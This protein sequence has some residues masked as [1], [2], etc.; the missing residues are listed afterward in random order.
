MFKCFDLIVNDLFYNWSSNVGPL[1]QTLATPPSLLMSAVNCIFSWPES[2][3][4]FT[5]KLCR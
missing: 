2:Q 3:I 1:N 4:H 5:F